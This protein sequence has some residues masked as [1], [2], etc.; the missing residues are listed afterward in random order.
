[1]IV[2]THLYQQL[3]FKS[4]NS[5]SYNDLFSMQKLTDAISKS[6]DTAVGLDDIHYQMLKHLPSEALNTLLESLN[7]IWVSGNFPDSW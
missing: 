4:N 7:N 3:R 1:M 5:E 6:H 2:T